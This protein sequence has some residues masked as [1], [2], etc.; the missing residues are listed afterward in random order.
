MSDG[1]VFGGERMLCVRGREPL[2]VEEF[3]RL[4]GCGCLAESGVWVMCEAYREPEVPG[5]GWQFFAWGGLG[6]RLR[7]G[8]LHSRR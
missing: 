6:R 7:G 8:L 2:C 4:P 3:S 5:G 1:H